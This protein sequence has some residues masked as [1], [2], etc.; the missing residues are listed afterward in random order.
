MKLFISHTHSDSDI[1]NAIV[2]FLTVSVG[3]NHNQIFCSSTDGKGVPLGLDFNEYIISQLKGEEAEVLAIV[4][5]NYYNSKYCMYELG[6][7][8]GLCRRIIPILIP[9]MQYGNLRDFIRSNISVQASA[10]KDLNSLRDDLHKKFDCNNVP[11]TTWEKNRKIFIDK[12]RELAKKEKNSVSKVNSPNYSS[13][14]KYKAVAFD[15]DGTVLQGKNFD[16]SWKEVWHHL[17]YDDIKRREL[18]QKHKD[19]SQNYTYEEWCN[20]CC[21]FFMDK[22]MNRKHI[23][24]II[25]KRNLKPAEGLL[26][27]LT[28]LKKHGIKTA[29]ISGGINTFFEYGLDENIKSLFDKVYFNNFHYDNSGFLEKVTPYQNKESDFIGKVIAFEDFCSFANCSLSEGVFVGEGTN[30]IE[31]ASHLSN[32][33]G[34]SIAYPSASASKEYREVA[35]VE[36]YDENM[37]A[38]LGEILVPQSN[39][40]KPYPRKSQKRR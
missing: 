28:A 23:P 5:N 38:I 25:A 39:N 10:E 11:T 36:I 35:S 3:I 16:Y 8:W 4:T 15:F 34:L 19:K 17:D 18:Y 27:T 20:D 33:N 24:E 37:S 21:K 12:V 7:A 31:V 6:A 32:N 2:E 22:K 13:L 14:Y 29:I 9:P 26:T 40:L 1:A 30:D